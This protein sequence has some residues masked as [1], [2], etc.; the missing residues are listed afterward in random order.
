MWI[1]DAGWASLIGFLLSLIIN[2]QILKYRLQKFSIFIRIKPA[3]MRQNF[4]TYISNRQKPFHNQNVLHNNFQVLAGVQL[5]NFKIFFK[6]SKDKS[7][8]TKNAQF[9]ELSSSQTDIFFCAV[10]VYILPNT[11]SNSFYNVKAPLSYLIFG[12]L[13][14][15][16]L[17]NSNKLALTQEYLYVLRVLCSS[18]A[19]PSWAETD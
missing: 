5:I 17:Q 11:F 7:Y 16:S 15:S 9:V 18:K 12:R 2:F 6:S 14:W 10:E 13:I 19:G 1:V 4:P 3:S 8:Y